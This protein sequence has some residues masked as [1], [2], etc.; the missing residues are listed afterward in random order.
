LS[1]QEKR[2]DEETAEEPR[3]DTI[4]DLDVPQ[5]Q[6]E[7]LAGGIKQTTTTDDIGEGP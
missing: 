4:D 7:E 1:E 3:A 2:T 6:Q 5:R